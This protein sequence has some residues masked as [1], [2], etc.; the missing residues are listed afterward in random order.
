[1]TGIHTADFRNEIE[2]GIG[3]QK[4]GTA[5]GRPLCDENQS[6]GYLSLYVVRADL[7][8]IPRRPASVSPKRTTV[9]PVSGTL[10]GALA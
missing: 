8:L 10:I 6:D 5:R 4:K 2:G 1:M 7:R 3:E 9:A